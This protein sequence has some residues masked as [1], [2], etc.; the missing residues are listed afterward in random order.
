MAYLA[1]V[2]N[3]TTAVTGIIATLDT[4]LISFNPAPNRI[5]TI[6]IGKFKIILRWHAIQ[7][8]IGPS[9]TLMRKQRICPS[10]TQPPSLILIHNK[11]KSDTSLALAGS[12]NCR[13]MIL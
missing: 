4:P 7:M 3:P 10:Y 12:C 6:S 9:C 13:G 8:L 11:S 5:T 1:V 2:V